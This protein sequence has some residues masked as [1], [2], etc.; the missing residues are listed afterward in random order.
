LKKQAAVI[1]LGALLTFAM[2]ASSFAQGYRH[3]RHARSGAVSSHS[4][5]YDSTVPER[6]YTTYPY[7]SDS[8]GGFSGAMGGVGR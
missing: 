7:S 8:N 1:A 2:T 4:G 5:Y 3:A 6:N